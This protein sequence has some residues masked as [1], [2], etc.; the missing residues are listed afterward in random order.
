MTIGIIG[1]GQL[2]KMLA[3]AA[4]YMGYKVAVMDPNADA[5]AMSISDHQIVASLYDAKEIEKLCKLSDVVT[6]EFENINSTV[7]EKLSS[8]FNI[9]QGGKILEIAQHRLKEKTAAT[10]A[11]IKVPPY[12]AVTNKEEL[13]DALNEIGR[14][15]VLKT[16]TGGYDGKGQL[17]IKGDTD[18]ELAEGIIST[19]D[20]ILESFVNYDLEISVIAIRSVNGEVSILPI[21]ENIHRNNILHKCIVPANLS[22]AIVEK[23]RE[24][25][26]EFVLSNDFYGPVA[27]EFFVSG[28]D[29]LFNEF[30]PRPHNSGHY[31][32]EGLY[33]SQF[34][35]HIRAITGMVL[36]DTSIRQKSIML[37]ILGQHM[38]YIEQL[39]ES[40]DFRNVK[41]H[42]Y[43]KKDAK[44]NRK[45]GHLTM[46]EEMPQIEEHL[47]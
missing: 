3:I 14:P 2:G 41:L 9:P 16:C 32:I 24:A 35:Q 17:V 18:L 30:A 12:K 28:D 1:G 21:G 6:Y 26:S 4:K 10:Q 46:F 38:D 11:G 31:S 44:L 15:A 23:A 42:L 43:G 19:N 8:T 22:D 37:N 29:V 7:V 25:A 36:G 20:C 39:V 34:E 33:T 40:D 47:K 45:M 13:V 27:I 5:P